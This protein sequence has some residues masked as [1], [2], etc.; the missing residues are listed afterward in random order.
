MP[1]AGET[2][3]TLRQIEDLELKKKIAVHAEDYDLAKQFKGQ[4]SQLQKSLE[5]TPPPMFSK[6][7]AVKPPPPAADLTD[8]EK[9]ANRVEAVRQ[10]ITNSRDKDH[11]GSTESVSPAEDPPQLDFPGTVLTD[12]YVV[13]Q[14]FAHIDADDSGHLTHEEL[15]HLL[16]VPKGVPVVSMPQS[17]PQLDFQAILNLKVGFVYSGRAARR[18][19]E[20][21][22]QGKFTSTPK[23]PPRL[24]F[25]SYTF[26]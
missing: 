5:P 25:E 9:H 18:G 20:R 26:I 7:N 14:L 19:C 2:F 23:S 10:G 6:E 8:E 13:I 1:G 24:D 11:G 22:V 17:T 12:P 21:D 4:I 16:G 3:E 15:Y